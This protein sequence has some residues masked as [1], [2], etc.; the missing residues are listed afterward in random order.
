MTRLSAQRS[1]TWSDAPWCLNSQQLNFSMD[2]DWNVLEHTLVATDQ[3]TQEEDE[4]GGQGGQG[5]GR[6]GEAYAVDEHVV[7][8][9]PVVSRMPPWNT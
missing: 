3:E 4:K 8:E 1:R 9:N 7:V 6:R 5:G 2:E